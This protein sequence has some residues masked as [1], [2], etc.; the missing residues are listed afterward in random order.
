MNSTSFKG[1]NAYFDEIVLEE[2]KALKQESLRLT[3]DIS[4]IIWIGLSGF[5]APAFCAGSFGLGGRVGSV[6]LGDVSAGILARADRVAPPPPVGP[7]PDRVAGQCR[8][9]SRPGRAD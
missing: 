6:Y 9:R 3:Q 7:A 5:I 1:H 2:Y 8:R 4:T